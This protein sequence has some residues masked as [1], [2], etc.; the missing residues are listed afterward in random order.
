[1]CSAIF[2]GWAEWLRLSSEQF[3]VITLHDIRCDINLKIQLFY[4]LIT[5]IVQNFN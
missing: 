1:M 5:N 3:L 4:I 2:G